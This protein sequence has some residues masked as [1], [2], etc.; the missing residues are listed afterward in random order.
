MSNFPSPY[1]KPKP[2]SPE[3]PFTRKGLPTTFSVQDYWIWAASNVLDNTQRGIV[4]E[5]IVSQA[6]GACNSVREEWGAFDL[7]TPKGIKIEVKSASYLQTW[8]QDRPSEISFRI[9]KTR[10][11]DPRTNKWGKTD[12]SCRCVCFLRS[13]P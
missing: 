9:A 13:R 8:H 2:L 1:R 12:S 5:Y 4:A 6:I 7:K 3:T 10:S 11:W